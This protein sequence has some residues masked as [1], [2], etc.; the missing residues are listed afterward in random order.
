MKISLLLLGAVL[1]GALITPGKSDKSSFFQSHFGYAAA[2]C[3]KKLVSSVS[4][5]LRA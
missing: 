2:F 5:R 3:G 1:R 4:W